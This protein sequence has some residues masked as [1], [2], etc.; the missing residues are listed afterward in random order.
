MPIARALRRLLVPGPPPSRLQGHHLH[1]HRLPLGH[2]HRLAS[3]AA[4]RGWRQAAGCVELDGHRFHYVWLRDHCPC[5]RCVDPHS[6]QKTHASSAVPLAVRPR[7]ARWLA[8]PEP[9]LE[10]VWDRPLAPLANPCFHEPALARQGSDA[11]DRA[12]HVS[13]YP[14]SWLLNH[15]YSSAARSRRAIARAP[16]HWDA[17]SIPGL[18]KSFPFQ[19]VMSSDRSLHGL[20]SS[21]HAVGIAFVDEMHVEPTTTVEALVERIGPVL[22]TFYGKSWDVRSVPEAKNVAY[23][24]VELG[25]HM[26]LM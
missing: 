19:S 21:L 22:E 26:D 6:R 10:I 13:R 5:A 8:M 9:T 20:L 23:T 4:P 15:S 12:G 2:G 16:T 14:L 25:L 11:A 7:A 24:A 1:L 18:L 17:A 3:S